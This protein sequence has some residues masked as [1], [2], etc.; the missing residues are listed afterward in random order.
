MSKEAE[1]DRSWYKSSMYLMI[2]TLADNHAA[3]M[4]FIRDLYD[5][6]IAIEQTKANEQHYEVPTAFHQLC[7]GR[8]APSGAD[9]RPTNEILFLLLAE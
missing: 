9:I 1:R 6:P 2:G 5:R 7:M 4:E 3:K 8:T